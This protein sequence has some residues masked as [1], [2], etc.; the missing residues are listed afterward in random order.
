MAVFFSAIL[1]AL[2]VAENARGQTPSTQPAASQVTVDVPALSPIRHWF[3][4]LADADPKIRDKAKVDLMGI[5]SNDLPALRQ[6]VI[7][8]QPI[9]HMQSAAL[10]DIVTH[11]YLSGK[12]YKAN[13]GETDSSGSVGPFCLGI[14]WATP[15]SESARLGLCVD[16][17]LAGFPAYRFLRKGDIILGIYID[18]KL[19]LETLP[20]RET[21]NLDTLREAIDMNPGAQNVELDVL[22]CGET[23]RVALR[24]A[25]RPT[26]ADVMLPRGMA[27][28]NSIRLDDA[29]AYWEENF[30]PLMPSRI[31]P[32]NLSAVP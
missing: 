27:N 14:F 25:P 1:V 32:S 23:I 3:D 5:T 7:D 29:D 15:P 26:D 11:V 30:E 28:F 6:L 24:M 2:I 18:P 4:Q 20:N 19:S 21:H 17:R 9:S 22:R 13:L 31:D 12:T 10:R 8:K 16:E